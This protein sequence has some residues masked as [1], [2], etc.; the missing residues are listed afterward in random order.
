M[1]LKVVKRALYWELEM[2]LSEE[3]INK[4]RKKIY[5]LMVKTLS[6]AIVAND[7]MR[8]LGPELDFKNSRVRFRAVIRS[9][10]QIHSLP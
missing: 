2:G 8:V 1:E 4:E 3:E 10:Q 6:E 5:R 9:G 7:L